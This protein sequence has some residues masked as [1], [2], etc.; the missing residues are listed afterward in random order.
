MDMILYVSYY[1]D[2]NPVRQ[3]ELD[4][5]IL[6]NMSLS[7]F[8]RVVIFNENGALRDDIDIDDHIVVVDTTARLCFSDFFQYANANNADKDTI[9]VLINSDILIGKGFDTISLEPDQIMCVSRHEKYEDGS[10]PIVIGG[11]SHD[12]WAWRGL[13]QCNNIGNF[14][15]GSMCCDG[16][17]ADQL[18]VSGYHLKNPAKGLFI[19]HYHNSQIRSDSNRLHV[20]YVIKGQRLGILMTEHDNIFS[21][22]DI[23][24]DGRN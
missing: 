17:L 12:A 9:H 18:F 10:T 15:M 19:Y 13:I 20:N 5:C 21:E 11:G 7:I 8:R 2:D 4:A 3:L 16:V 14:Y 6:H 22:N 23:Y 24:K 1:H